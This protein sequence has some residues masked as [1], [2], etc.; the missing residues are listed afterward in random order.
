MTP[1]VSRDLS[2]GRRRWLQ[3]NQFGLYVHEL[4]VTVEVDVGG[5][6]YLL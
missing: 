3:L 2:D 6:E 5:D 4:Y 1:G